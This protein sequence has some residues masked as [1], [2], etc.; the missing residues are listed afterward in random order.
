MK[1]IIF[2]LI[3]AVNSSV[4]FGQVTLTIEGSVVKNTETG[5]WSGVNIQRNVPTSF[6]YRNNHVTSE[7]LSGYLLQAGDEGVAST[8]NNLDGEII[9]GNKFV[10]NGTDKTS[11]T[12]GIF[13]GY[14][15]NALIKYN[16]LNKVPMGI[17][18]KSNGMTNTS[19]GVAYNIINKT[20]AVALVVKGMNGVNIY[21]NTF[22]SDQ[23]PYTG[24]GEGTWRGLIDIYTN[25]DITPAKVSAGTKI[26]NNIFYTKYQIYNIYVYEAECL[27]GFE[28][29]YNVFYCESGTPLFN[30]LGSSKTFAQWQALGYDLHSAVVN[31]NFIN[32]TDFVPAKRLDYGTNLGI[33]WQTGLSLNAQWGN[34]DPSTSNQNGT[35][36]AGARIY[37]EAAVSQSILFYRDQNDGIFWLKVPDPFQNER[38]RISVFD[39][40]G[41]EVYN[42]ILLKQE[43]SK[44]LN[45]YYLGSGIYI[46]MIIG[47]GVLFTRKFLRI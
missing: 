1:N 19:G 42:G 8:N 24:P 2:P 15:K 4:L 44:Q 17:V 9:T 36:Q 7:N 32:L 22:Y 3:I 41:K 45:L 20:Q 25:T 16:Y 34:S 31:P 43:S 39:I 28:S 10:W 35:W 37:S 12:H 23:T 6:T 13:T 40:N 14:N 27:N 26:K 29:D 33:S 21:N 46:L 38:N 11:I 5:A 18:R 47:D 30:Y